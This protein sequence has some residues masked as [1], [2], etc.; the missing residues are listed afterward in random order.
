[1]SLGRV[2]DAFLGLC[3]L[4]VVAGVAL[5]AWLA[6]D[7]T[8][9]DRS[10][11]QLTTGTLGS[12]LQEGSDVKLRGVP[13][14][15]VRTVAAREGGA[16]L[17]LA[18]E[19]DVLPDLT[20]ATTARLLPKTLFGERYVA[21]QP[22]AGPELEAGDTIKQDS[23]D[24]AVELEQVLDELLPVLKALQPHKLNATLSEL[25]TM[26]RGNGGDIGE[27]FADWADYLHKLNPLVPELTDDLASL[28]RVAGHLEEAAPDLLEALDTMTV[29]AKTLV[30]QQEQLSDTFRSVTTTAQDSD[31]WLERNRET[32][33]VLSDSGRDALRAVSPYATSFPCLFSALRDYV[34]E[35]A[36]NLGKGTDKH[37]IHAVV[38]VSGIRQPYPQGYVPKLRKGKARCPYVTGQTGSRPTMTGVAEQIGAPPSD[39]VRNF[40]ATTG[41]GDQNS[42]SE[43]QLIA[44]VMAP[45]AGMAPE[46]Y[47]TWSSLLLGPALRGTK[48]IVR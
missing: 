18:L 48:V 24:E 2:R 3:Y 14:G 45:T 26:L 11:V 33:V 9:V 44:E 16:E 23:S 10:E 25:A 8:F 42:E 46:E 32:I 31:R 27:V 40:G 38:S 21:L 6:Y 34:P 29:T 5:G 35:M 37:G 20:R 19:P 41:L 28:G 4:A 22:A 47:P 12:A 13:V 30:D 43:N 15:T 7:Q 39:R 17:T 1:M 36:R